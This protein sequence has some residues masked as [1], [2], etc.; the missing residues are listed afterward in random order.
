MTLA[1]LV[2]GAGRVTRTTIVDR[3][4]GI[5]SVATSAEEC[6]REQIRTWLFPASSAG[7]YRFPVRF[8]RR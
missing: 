4:W 5:G 1:V 2:D 7:T 3:S 8:A 6:L